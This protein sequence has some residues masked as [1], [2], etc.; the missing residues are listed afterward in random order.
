MNACKDDTQLRALAAEHG[1]PLWVMDAPT[2]RQQMAS[3]SAFDTV[4]YAQKAN[5]NVHL[6]RLLRAGGA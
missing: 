5:P 2:V 6:L 4:R 1:T 3:L